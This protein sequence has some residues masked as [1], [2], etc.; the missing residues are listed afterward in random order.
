MDLR[1]DAGR[2]PGWCGR[3]TGDVGDDVDGDYL[4]AVFHWDH[5]FVL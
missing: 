5:R 3:W 4:F 2:A 1:S